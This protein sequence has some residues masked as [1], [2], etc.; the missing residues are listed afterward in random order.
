MLILEFQVLSF[1][2]KKSPEIR[3][4]RLSGFCSGPAVPLILSLAIFSVSQR[5][6]ENKEG[7]KRWLPEGEKKW[8]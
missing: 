2:E 1:S 8:Q 6:K 3:K 5:E 4:E 7:G